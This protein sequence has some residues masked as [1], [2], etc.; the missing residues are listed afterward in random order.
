MISLRRPA[1]DAIDAYREASLE[2]VPTCTPARTPPHG[3]TQERF[4]RQVGT[5]EHAFDHARLG[6]LGWAAHGG[7]GVQV[8]PGD[9]P[10][11]E[12]QTVALLTRQAGLWVLAACRISSVV[13]RPAEFGFTY[14]TLPGHPECGY[15][16]FTVRRQPGRVRFDIEAVSRPGVPLVRL[17]APVARLLQRRAATAY[18]DGLTRWVDATR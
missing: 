13:D 16:S 3:F 14:S 4:S 5:G 7:A 12:G 15:E 9:A 2:A 18:L 8:F 6:L 17:G 11:V 1:P 10:V